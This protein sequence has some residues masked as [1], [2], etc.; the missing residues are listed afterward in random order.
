MFANHLIQIWA[1]DRVSESFDSVRDF[2]ACFASHLIQ[3]EAS[4]RVSRFNWLSSG[5]VNW[6]SSG[7][8]IA[9]RES[10]G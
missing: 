6:F 9:F 8:Q 2:R 4:E 7:L 5:R 3:F 10:F 1:S